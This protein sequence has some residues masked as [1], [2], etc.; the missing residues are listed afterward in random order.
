MI[1][2]RPIIDKSFIN[3]VVIIV[4][5][6]TQQLFSQ[7]DF[8]IIGLPDTQYY[9]ENAQGSGSGSGSGDIATFKAQTNWIVSNRID[10]SIVYVVH[11]GDCVD[12]ADDST[13]W[14]GA[15]DAMD[16][17]EDS[18]TTLLADGITYG[19][20][21]GNHDQYEVGSAV[22]E[23]STTKLYNKYFGV[24]CFLGRN[25]YG[26]HHGNDND[27]HYDLF[28]VGTLKF[29]VVYIEYHAYTDDT[30]AVTWADS[31]LAAYGDRHGI[32]VSHKL[33][34]STGLFGSAA[35][36]IY[37]R[38]K[39]NANLF[40]MLCAHNTNIGEARLTN[41]RGGDST[42]VV[43]LMSNYQHLENG[44]DGWLRIMEFSPTDNK[45]YVKTYSPT[46]DSF[47]TNSE[48]QF[49]IDYDFPNPPLPVELAFFTGALNGNTVE[50]RWRTA[51]EVNNYDFD[52]ERA[53]E[54]SD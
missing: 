50:L 44:G 39:D 54:K 8:T 19:I 29:V 21:V 18:L 11:L 34:K 20:A 1:F 13:E 52:I 23:D 31:I 15:V 46:L 43:T 27:N 26:G 7:A 17:L 10:S 9:S 4:F 30:L 12:S 2:N 5:I 48:S 32:L 45:I 36:Y 40:L 28:T 51:T 3:S 49:E 37:A 47:K 53:A 14:I 38:V 33:L 41:S 42:D 35:N 16:N 6:I 22:V 24:S 25:Y